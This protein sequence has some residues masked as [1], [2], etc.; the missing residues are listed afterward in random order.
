MNHIPLNHQMFIYMYIMLLGNGLVFKTS[1]HVARAAS[2]T[3]VH[4]TSS[5]YTGGTVLHVNGAGFL[6]LSEPRCQLT[7]SSLGY[8]TFDVNTIINNTYMTCVVPAVSSEQ[9]SSIKETGNDTLQLSVNGATGHI[10]IRMF[11]LAGII[12][13]SIHPNWGYRTESTTVLV[14]GNGFINTSSITCHI[15]MNSIPAVYYNTS[16]IC[17]ELPPHSITY[18]AVVDAYLNGQAVSR[19]S[20]TE[21]NITNLF[22]YFAT[23]PRPM[24]CTY[25][26][27][28]SAIIITFDRE[29]EIGGEELNPTNISNSINCNVIFT[30]IS[31]MSLGD[32]VRCNWLNTLQ[33]DIEIQLG[34]NN[35]IKPGSVLSLLHNSIRTRYA[36]FSKQSQGDVIVQSNRIDLLPV[37]IL[38]S[39]Q[40]IP[41]CGNITLY[42]SNSL[43]PGP[44]PM[45]YM[46]NITSIDAYIGSGLE[47]DEFESLNSLQD[48]LP[49]GFTEQSSV[50][51]SSSLFSEY[52]EYLFTLTVQNYLGHEDTKNITLTKDPTTDPSTPLIRVIGGR[53]KRISPN[54]GLIIETVLVNYCT[55]LNSSLDYQWILQTENKTLIPPMGFTSNYVNFKSSLILL[56]SHTLI[57]HTNYLLTI[58]VTRTS[59]TLTTNITSNVTLML[60]RGPARVDGGIIQGGGSVVLYDVKDNIPLE[61]G[62]TSS[63]GQTLYENEIFW[64]CRNEHNNETCGGTDVFYRRS[65]F[66]NYIPG[67]LLSAGSYEIT[68]SFYSQSIQYNASQRIIISDTNNSNVTVVYLIESLAPVATHRKTAIRGTVR[69]IGSGSVTWRC[70]RAAGKRERERRER[71]RERERERGGGGR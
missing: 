1:T 67:S 28:Y 45:L 42:G 53:E 5:P 21:Y 23:P 59:V 40:T 27:S 31:V 44:V 37:A 6:N 69:S 61:L 26:P 20:T 7:L 16:L 46:W 49:K 11:D 35:T 56:P 15:G 43:Y 18:Q 60:R 14:H 66:E 33:R 41:T 70:I 24:S 13:T 71:E 29:V 47:E 34:I 4:P 58:S 51:V 9:V 17:C 22:T 39:P 32:R 10:N 50:T 65:S 64:S 25:E 52:T 2:L 12:I 19:L 62:I 3:S 57:E 63:S 48:S 8:I 36:A 55:T 68:T 38:D 54:K 30:S